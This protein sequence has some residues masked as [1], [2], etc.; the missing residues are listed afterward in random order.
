MNT[1]DKTPPSKQQSINQSIKPNQSNNTTNQ[2]TPTKQHHQAQ[3]TTSNQPN[4][5]NQTT[6]HPSKKQ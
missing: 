2:P 3:T 1:N 4:P 6:A 5:T